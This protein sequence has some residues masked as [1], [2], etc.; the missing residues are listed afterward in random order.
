MAIIHYVIFCG[1]CQHW[2]TGSDFRQL[3]STCLDF[4]I[5]GEISAWK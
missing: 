3:A 5:G 2:L 4:K 1:I